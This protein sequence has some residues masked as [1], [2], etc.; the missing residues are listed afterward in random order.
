MEDLFEREQ[1]IL[2][3]ATLHMNEILNGAPYDVERYALL[4]REYGKLLRQ[5]RRVTR[6]SDR[7][8][9]NLNASKLDLLNKVRYDFLTGIYNRRFM[10]DSLH[11]LITGMSHAGGSWLSVLMIDI[12]HFKRYNDTYG[13]QMGDD[14]LRIV[15]RTLG[16]SVTRE[17]DFVARYGSEEFIVV[18][19]GANESGARKIAAKLLENIM[20]CKIPHE[21]NETGDIVT[22]SIGAT[23][24]YVHYTQ[25][26][27]D[28]IKRADQALY[29]AK[30]AGRNQYIFVNLKEE[31]DIGHAEILQHD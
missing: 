9:I 19:P 1:K 4:V 29:L 2:D 21:N 31:N 20:S 24:G 26:A 25:T 7:T 10:E 23:T 13:H 15:A 6:L 17:N 30:Q 14:C 22:V 16:D 12:D 27:E 8:T 18:L 28:Y 11:R 3:E 5:L